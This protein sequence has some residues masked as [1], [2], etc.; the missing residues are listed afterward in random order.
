MDLKEIAASSS[1]RH[2]WERHRFERYLETLRRHV[3]GTAR[4]VL[5]V[6]AGDGFF[7]RELAARWPTPLAVTC[8][9]S[10]YGDSATTDAGV[11]QTAVQ[12]DDAFD[13][14]LMLDVAEHVPDDRAFLGSIVAKNLAPG[15]TMLFAVPAWPALWTSHDVRLGHQRRYTPKTGAALLAGAGLCI[16]QSG[17]L[18]PTLLPMRALQ[19]VRERYFGVPVSGLDRQSGEGALAWALDRVLRVDRHLQGMTRSLAVTL[20]GLSWWA[21]C[22]R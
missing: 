16:T 10:G 8:W 22:T 20:P 6:G 14:V 15:G 5:D 11:R 9:D 17:S 1:G 12:P 4:T 3:P 2:P 7:A 21:L 13:V 19:M 18:F